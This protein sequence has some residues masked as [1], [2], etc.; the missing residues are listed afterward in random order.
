MNTIYLRVRVLCAICIALS[1]TACA[2][3]VRDEAARDLREGHYEAAISQLQEGL[4]RYPDNT[5][6]RASLLTTQE[7]A[8][9]RLIAQASR[10]RLESR[11]DAAAQTLRRAS[12]IDPN[13][14][15]L[16]SLKAEFARK[17]SV[18][19]T[20]AEARTLSENNK[21][22][23]ALKIV[24]GALRKAPRQPDLLTLQKQLE[25]DI[26]LATDTTGRRTLAENRPVSLDF[27][28]T[29]LSTV[30][31]A[32]TKG[33]G[34]NFILDRDVKTD[35]RTTV[36][37]RNVRFDDALDL[38]ASSNQLARR[39]I[40]PRT[41]LIYPNTP[42]KR[43]EHQEQV[44]RVF[45]LANAD[46]KTTANML[47]GLLRIKDVFVDERANFVAL[48]EPPEIVAL[49]ERL[50]ALHDVGEAEVMLEVEVLEIKTSRLTEL[51]INF[52]NSFTLTPLSAS[53][54]TAGAGLTVGGLRNINSDQVG[55]S[56][57]GLLVNLRR[58]VGDFNTL[59][60]PRIRTRSKDKAKILIGDKI[61]VIT[62]TAS[63]TGFVSEN[64]NY[65][66]VGLKL[67]VE[68]VV[69]PDDEVLI[70][71][72]L[73]VSS[74]AREVRTTS[75]S[76]AYQIGTRNANTTLRLKDGETQL[77]G[78]LISN[79][80]RTNANRI[81]GLGDLPIAGRLFSSQKDEFQRTELVLAI[82]PR[83]LR[84][85]PKPEVWQSELWVGTEADT[86]L[87]PAPGTQ[88]TSTSV[89]ASLSRGTGSLQAPM[90][91]AQPAATKAQSAIGLPVT[92]GLQVKWTGPADVRV[93]QEFEVELELQSGVPLRG[94]PLEV[95]YAPEQLEILDV[96][97]GN[98]FNRSQPGSSF[99]QSIN[100]KT[101]K[102]GIGIMASGDQGAAGEGTI[103]RLKVRAKTAGNTTL[104]LSS[105]APFGRVAIPALPTSPSMEIKIQ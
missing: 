13:D 34:I 80:D 35:V 73:E 93:G 69:S 96:Q 19:S 29:P 26:R 7:T 66:D 11:Y 77:L 31:D 88:P 65:L 103:F 23:A 95:R 90:P 94:L 12:A 48:R 52:P 21:K 101:G 18:R 43:R 38:V 99:T 45:Y 63:S 3:L 58:E 49:A 42:E 40:D 83:I 56:V 98:F 44:I 72:G 30:L 2:Q 24:E 15:R 53:G 54:A 17:D 85:A 68:P 6:L 20:L 55:V 39:V 104:Q 47:R 22:D 100:N 87:R 4:K 92:T 89:S 10:E 61:P 51:G 67:E 59:A 37:L 36:L 1:L 97:E 75:G 81:P 60:N 50:V 27:R 57:A 33:S 16:V 41:V 9:A 71:L 25:T 64:I 74:L 105:F 14:Q 91:S 78:G 70:K 8:I 32:M 79:E 28:G 46:A 102:V 5:L 84:N 82:T 62:S 76:L 86:R